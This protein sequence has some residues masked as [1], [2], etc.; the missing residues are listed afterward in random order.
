MVVPA[1]RE[2]TS[3]RKVDGQR[4]TN[5]Y[6]PTAV[7]TLGILPQYKLLCPY[8][9]STPFPEPSLGCPDQSTTQ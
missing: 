2:L 8:S 6:P 4:G 3:F 7:Q 9:S 1:T 5:S